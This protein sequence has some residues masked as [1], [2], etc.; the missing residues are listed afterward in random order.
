MMTAR[1]EARR[2]LIPIDGSENSLR[3]LRH[4][5]QGVSADGR[6][7]HLDVVHVQPQFPVSTWVTRRM[8]EDHRAAQSDAALAPARRLLERHKLKANFHM[9]VGEPARVI[10]EL[11]RRRRSNEIVIGSRGLGALKGLLLGSVTTKVIHMAATPVTV[12]P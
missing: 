6:A 4:V 2:V 9:R 1:R 8:I 3:A 12:V 11:A 10:V 7:V 5:A